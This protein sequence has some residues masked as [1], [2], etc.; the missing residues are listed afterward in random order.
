MEKMLMK[1][2]K[3]IMLFLILT[4]I[5]SSICYFIYINFGK[6]A[7]NIT[8]LLMWCP[9]LS[10]I[11][12]RNIYYKKEKVFGFGKCNGKFI[13]M[14][15][16]I[17]MLYL[18][19][20]Y[21]LYWAINPAAF[22]GQVYSNSIGL[23]IYAYFS[24]ILTAMGEEIGWRGFLLPKMSEMFHYKYAIIICGLIWA[25]WHY[26]L[27]FAGLYQ[28]GTPVYYQIPMFTAEV[29]LMTAILG[30]LRMNS[31]NIW[32]AILL[33]ASH[34][35]FDQMICGPL[36]KA[37][38]SVYYVGETGFLTVIFVLVITVFLYRKNRKKSPNL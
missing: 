7:S 8:A 20:S 19:V 25:A 12:A 6:S 13:V 24:S 37:D 14:S 3:S 21:G 1:N 17:P 23:M 2:R 16:L 34:N 32:P 28:A 15:I 18:G 22:T 31:G 33:H 26:P 38:K 35:Y 29:V 30:F 9:G 4:F 10:A 11:I 36:T 5:L 27:M